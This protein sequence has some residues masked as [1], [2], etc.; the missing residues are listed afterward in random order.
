MV[1]ARAPRDPHEPRREP[2]NARSYGQLGQDILRVGP[3]VKRPAFDLIA[4]GIY[5][6]AGEI[7]PEFFQ[8]RRAL[9]QL[10]TH[11]PEL[12]AKL[13]QL[14]AARG[15]ADDIHGLQH[16][17]DLETF[18]R[19]ELEVQVPTLAARLR[20]LGEDHTVD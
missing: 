15:A 12:E 20:E 5:D 16:I 8:K 2:E 4:R 18:Q 13:A 9:R 17:I 14:N 3:D 19:R 11:I 6:P 7:R 10:R 1:F